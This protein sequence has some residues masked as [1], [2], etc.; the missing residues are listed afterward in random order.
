[1]TLP[2]VQL[3]AMSAQNVPV[4][5]T[6]LNAREASFLVGA[7]SGKAVATGTTAAAENTGSTT[8]TTT[9]TSAL[10]VVTAVGAKIPTRSLISNPVAR[11]CRSQQR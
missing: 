5:N 4:F 11:R 1:M 6:T 2:T 10:V 7:F 8:G 9:T 3:M